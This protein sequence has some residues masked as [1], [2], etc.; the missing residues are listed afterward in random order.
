[1]KTDDME[2]NYKQN[3]EN[4]KKNKEDMQKL[5]RALED[6]FKEDKFIRHIVLVVIFICFAFIAWSF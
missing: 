5:S 2:F 3:Q 1:M 4:Y 6:K